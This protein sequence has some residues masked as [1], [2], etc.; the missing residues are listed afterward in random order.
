MGSDAEPRD[1]FDFRAK[2]EIPQSK[3]KEIWG[4]NFSDKLFPKV[5]AFILENREF[6]KTLKRMR[7]SPC[8]RDM[9]TKEWGKY[10]PESEASALLFHTTEGH[11]ILRSGISKNDLDT[12]LEHELRHIYKGEA[13]HFDKRARASV[14]QS[15]S[16]CGN[17]HDAS[18]LG[19]EFFTNP[20]QQIRKCWVVRCL[21]HSGS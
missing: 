11:Y 12:D 5:R 6:M 17:V 16:L 4:V 14:G 1:E 18:D 9:G 21:F 8:L 3:L 13:S 10:I 7:T 2:K 20:I 19:F 15:C